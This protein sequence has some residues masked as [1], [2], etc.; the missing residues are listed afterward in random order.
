MALSGGKE[1]RDRVWKGKVPRARKEAERQQKR[2]MARS[3]QR[4]C[5]SHSWL[6][7]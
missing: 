2:A 4:L 7:T 5:S 1:V 6:S 3:I